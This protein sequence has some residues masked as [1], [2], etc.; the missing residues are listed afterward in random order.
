M[1]TAFAIIFTFGIVVF[2]HELGHFIAAKKSGVRVEKFSLGFGPELFGFTKGDTRYLVS[3]VPLGGYVKMAGENPEEGKE[4]APDEFLV[5]PWYKKVFIVF[6]G[7]VMNFVLAVLLFALVAFVWGIPVPKTDEARI[8][9]VS[10]GSPAERAGLKKGDLIMSID[11]KRVSD[12]EDMSRIIHYS[13][14]KELELILARKD[15]ELTVNVTPEFNEQSHV[16]LIGIAAPFD[17]VK[18]NMF[19]SAMTGIEQTADWSVLIVKFIGW[20]VM[21][22]V[23]AEV[24]GPVGVGQLI[25]KV[26][27]TGFEN[28]L[29]FIGIISVHLGIFNLLPVPILDGGHIMFFTVEGIKGSPIDP[30]KLN[31][32]QIVGMTLLIA[33]MLFATYKDFLRLFIK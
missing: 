32:A 4:S 33:L 31:I 16:G 5:Q 24:S 2:F 1:F 23:K 18:M 8:G 29:Y 10:A 17:M 21:G 15:Q 22:K 30:K 11:E 14:N 6:S 9:E 12:W 7:P 20:M 27:K 13:A 26:A 19:Q 25:A 3:L 28:L